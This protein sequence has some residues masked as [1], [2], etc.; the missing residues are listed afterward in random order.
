LIDDLKESGPFIQFRFPVNPQFDPPVA[1]T[2]QYRSPDQLRD[3]P[4]A[5]YGLEAFET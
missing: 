1:P 4:A 3:H 2:R 5:D